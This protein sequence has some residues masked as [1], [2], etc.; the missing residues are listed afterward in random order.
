MTRR[1]IALTKEQSQKLRELRIKRGVCVQCG[2]NRAR[3]NKRMCSSCYFKLMVA[4][5]DGYQPEMDQYNSSIVQ[6]GMRSPDTNSIRF[7]ERERRDSSRPTIVPVR[8]KR[9]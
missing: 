7:P 1:P 3:K 5:D 4:D 8:K 9:S 2:I 6:Q